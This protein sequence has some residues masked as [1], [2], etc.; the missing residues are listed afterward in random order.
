MVT[1]HNR[2]ETAA[3]HTIEELRRLLEERERELE[4]LRAR[5]RRL[6]VV[7]ADVLSAASHAVMNPLTIIQSYL[8][9]LLSDLP[10]GLSE[11]QISF[12]ET[13]H[14]ATGRVKKIVDNL[15]ELAAWETNAAELELTDLSLEELV[16][17][18]CAEFS[19]RAAESSVELDVS[20]GEA[21]TRIEGDASR[22]AG[23]LGTLLSNAIRLT[24]PGGRVEVEVGRDDRSAVVTVTDGGPG[25]P[26]EETARVFEP[27]L[28]VQGG[29]AEQR[30][31]AGL[32]LAVAQRQ[33]RAH[34]GSIELVTSSSSGSAFRLVFPC[35]L[36]GSS[37]P[38]D[39]PP[40]PPRAGNPS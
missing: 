36:A 28:R 40:I 33:M 2:P 21:E 20:A 26:E 19:V 29:T 35:D 17:K 6:E 37:K 16:A 14:I 23:I 18:A 15:V 34:G 7:G 8:E 13:A 10:E 22:I 30:R 11:E 1:R 12:V 4:E 38:A 39:C 25:I 3:D 27:F 9:I 24:P 32:G 5:S 31:G